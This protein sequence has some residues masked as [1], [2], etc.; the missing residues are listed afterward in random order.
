MRPLT[1]TLGAV[2]AAALVLAVAAGAAPSDRTG[3]ATARAWG[4]QVIV[5][6]GESAASRTLSAPGNADAHQGAFSYPADGSVACA[7]SVTASVSTARGV[8]STARASAGAVSLSLFG[9]A[10]EASTVAGEAGAAAGGAAPAG[11]T[12]ASEVGG[13][14][15][16][17]R[18]VRPTANLQ[19]PLG[20]WGYLVVLEQKGQAQSSPASGYH[21]FVA[22]LD[23]FLTADHAGLPAGSEV[24]VGY[25]EATA[26]AAGAP[27]LPS[28]PS[29]GRGVGGGPA[30]SAGAKRSRPPAR[31]PKLGDADRVFPVYGTSSFADNFGALRGDVSGDWHHG[32]DVFAALGTPVL[33]CADGIVFSVGWNRVGGR[34]LWLRDDR[35][36]DFYYAH[37]A[38]YSA[39][40][41]NGAQVK[42]GDVLGFVGDTGDAEGT[43]YHLHF[44]VHPAGLLARGYDGAVNPSGYLRS[45]RRLTGIPLALAAAS[46]WVTAPRAS[47]A[48]PK[49]GAVLLQE[50]DISTASGLTPDSL[51]RVFEP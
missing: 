43:P 17:G 23:V 28:A 21:E 8:R 5:A 16:L 33:A 6:G 24:Q 38:G 14:V 7:A 48:A 4:I 25:A 11:D 30:P 42:A 32:V 10:I 31:T 15:V 9:G 20:D 37:L 49:P 41:A 47:A 40:A 29:N 18:P 27:P 2:T 22:A 39:L 45:W 1:L 13:L 50:Q 51:T 35:G 36:N 44:E 34:R 46:G 12:G 26:Q 3:G 19:L